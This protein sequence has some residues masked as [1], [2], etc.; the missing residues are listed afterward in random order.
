MNETVVLD[1]MLKFTKSKKTLKS[2]KLRFHG[3]IIIPL[4]FWQQIIGILKESSTSRRP[5]L[6][7]DILPFHLDKEVVSKNTISALNLLNYHKFSFNISD[8]ITESQSKHLQNG[9]FDVAMIFF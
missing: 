1:G 5:F 8:G 4:S 7:F 3:D 6:S 9:M 2:I